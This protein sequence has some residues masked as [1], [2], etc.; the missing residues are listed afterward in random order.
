MNL[1]I[2]FD[3][4]HHYLNLKSTNP[5]ERGFSY[6]R[7]DNGKLESSNSTFSGYCS[8]ISKCE[9]IRYYLYTPASTLEELYTLHPELF[10]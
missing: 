5:D 9:D 3:D 2:E 4:K 7:A 8:N 1:Y 10:I 6:L